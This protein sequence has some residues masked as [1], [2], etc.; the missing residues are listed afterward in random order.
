MMEETNPR[1]GATQFSIFASLGNAGMTIG[2]TASGS[3][4]AILGFTRTFLYS[5][6]FFGPELLI[7]YFIWTIRI[8]KKKKK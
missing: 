8:V 1:I 7:L 5:A 3:L 2:E 6:W 4:V